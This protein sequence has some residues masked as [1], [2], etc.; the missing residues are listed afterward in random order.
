MFADFDIICEGANVSVIE[1]YIAYYVSV[2]SIIMPPTNTA[3]VLVS[4][5]CVVVK[6]NTVLV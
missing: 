6:V 1:K 2:Q 5:D 4:V 3:D